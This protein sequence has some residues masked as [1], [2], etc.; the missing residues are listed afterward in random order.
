MYVKPFVKR[1][2]NNP[3]Y[4][5]ARLEATQRPTMPFVATPH[6]PRERAG[7][8]SIQQPERHTGNKRKAERWN[9]R[10]H[11]HLLGSPRII[12]T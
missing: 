12:S 9:A 4:A 10:D 1:Q 5:G 8:A 6:R 11:P 3:N 7:A 2:K